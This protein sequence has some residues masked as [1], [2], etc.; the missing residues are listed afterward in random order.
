MEEVSDEGQWPWARRIRQA[1]SSTIIT[2]SPEGE[3]KG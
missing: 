1:A 2:D 3:K